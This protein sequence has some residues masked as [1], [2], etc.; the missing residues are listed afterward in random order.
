MI[1][2]VVVSGFDRI[3]INKET[4]NETLIMYYYRVV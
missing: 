1:Y 4:F 2:S 3:M